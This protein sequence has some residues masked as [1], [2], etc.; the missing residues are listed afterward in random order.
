MISHIKYLAILC[1]MIPGLVH[2]DS[3]VIKEAEVEI[4]IVDEAAILEE[5]DLYS[6]SDEAGVKK[7]LNAEGIIPPTTDWME[8]SLLCEKLY[9]HLKSTKFMCVYKYSK[10]MDQYNKT[11]RYCDHISFVEI[12]GGINDKD[13]EKYVECM[14][15]YGFSD[16]ENW[17]TFEYPL[18]KKKQPT[19]NTEEENAEQQ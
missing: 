4:L 18:K 16:P 10:I 9:T 3:S 14:Q 2:A 15:K 13:E 6:F 12:E 11:K 19:T 8:V 1:I 7:L 17:K 5:H